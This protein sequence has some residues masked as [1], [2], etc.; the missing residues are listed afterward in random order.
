M[1]CYKFID[2][3]MDCCVIDGFVNVIVLNFG[4]DRIFNGN[5]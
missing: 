5:I 2:Y 1:G 4:F 3:V